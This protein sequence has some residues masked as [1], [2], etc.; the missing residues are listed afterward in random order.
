L[1]EAKKQ[2][3]AKAFVEARDKPFQPEPFGPKAK[4]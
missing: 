4:K 3:G 1:E 2:G